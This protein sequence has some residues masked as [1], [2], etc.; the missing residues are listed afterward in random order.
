MIKEFKVNE[1]ITLK[2]EDDITNLYVNDDLFRQCKLLLLNIPTDED[3]GQIQ[4]IDEAADNLGW[5]PFGQMA[6]DIRHKIPPETQFWAHCSNIQAWIENEYNTKILHH[7]IAFPLLKKL[8]EVGDSLAKVR[9]KEEVAERLE[10]STPQVLLFLIQEKYLEIFTTEELES[11][12]LNIEFNYPSRR[13]YL[14]YTP[15]IFNNFLYDFELSNKTIVIL[16]EHLFKRFYGNLFDELKQILLRKSQEE[17]QI[18]LFKLTQGLLNANIRRIKLYFHF[19]NREEKINLLKEAISHKFFHVT[20]ELLTENPGLLNRLNEEQVPLLV[21]EALMTRKPSIISLLID[22]GHLTR[23][24]KNEIKELI[25]DISIYGFPEKIVAKIEEWFSWLR[26]GYVR[27]RSCYIH[28]DDVEILQEIEKTLDIKLIWTPFSLVL[29]NYTF[30]I[31]DERRVSKLYIGS[32]IGKKI[33]NKIIEK[34]HT[35]ENLKLLDLP[36]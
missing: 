27:F 35:L 13:E 6:P 9:F 8:E 5:S 36:D 21:K 16:F 4:S 3:S 22:E 12:I 31:D 28:K 17:T 11:L 34:I 19:L 23:L 29:S 33:P 18:I 26:K 20:F 14:K 25:E 2:L 7:S 30:E 10:S 15:S 1:Y 24:P 32:Q